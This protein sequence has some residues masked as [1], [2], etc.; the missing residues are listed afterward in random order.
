MSWGAL[1]AGKLADR[2]GRKSTLL[3]STLAFAISAY[4]TTFA[5]SF[6][7]FSSARIVAGIG[8]GLASTVVPPC[9]WGK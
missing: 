6:A 9:T 7:I 2:I 3:L 5:D 1:A 8:I 4:G